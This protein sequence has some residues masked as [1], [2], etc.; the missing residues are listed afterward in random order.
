MRKILLSLLSIVL[1]STVAVG[2]TKAYYD[3]TETSNGN[4]FAAGTLDL[5]VDGNNGTNTVKF[6][7]A[8]MKPG[9]QPKG[10]YTLN[11]V[12]SQWIPRS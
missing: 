7:I 10:T 8:N 5:T 3:D 9:D 12:G 4:T 6:T 1:V 11:N 2:A